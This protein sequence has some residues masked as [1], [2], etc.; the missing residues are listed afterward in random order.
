VGEGW[1]RDGVLGGW[2]ELGKHHLEEGK[3]QALFRYVFITQS[4]V[5]RPTPVEHENRFLAFFVINI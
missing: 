4:L 2:V 1:P 5:R 3:A